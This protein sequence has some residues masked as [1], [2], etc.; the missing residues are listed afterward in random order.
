M[1]TVTMVGGESQNFTSGGRHPFTTG[2]QP[3][4]SIVVQG[5][6]QNVDLADFGSATPGTPVVIFGQWKGVNQVW[7][8]RETLKRTERNQ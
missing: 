6:N 8:F 5:S 7:E 3:D 1:S 4:H 2:P